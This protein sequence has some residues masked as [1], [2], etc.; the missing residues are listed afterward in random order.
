LNDVGGIEAGA[1]A[2]V[3][4]QVDELTQVRPVALEQPIHRGV[5]TPPNLLE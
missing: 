3:E 4:A 1:E 2:A 5:I